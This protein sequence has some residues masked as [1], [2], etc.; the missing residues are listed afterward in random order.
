MIETDAGVKYA[1]DVAA[2]HLVDAGCR[3]D[4]VDPPHLDDIHAPMAGN[5][6]DRSQGHGLRPAHVD[7]ER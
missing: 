1:V 7:H 4:F 5:P 2:G 3:V 6:G